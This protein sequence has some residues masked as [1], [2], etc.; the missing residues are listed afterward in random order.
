MSV[1]FI[2]REVFVVFREL[3]LACVF[4]TTISNVKINVKIRI[5]HGRDGGLVDRQ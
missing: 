1:H 4:N 3:L 5:A 2:S